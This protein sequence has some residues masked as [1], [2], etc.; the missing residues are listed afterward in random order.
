MLARRRL[1]GRSP[2][3]GPS[4]AAFEASNRFVFDAFRS[5]EDAAEYVFPHHLLCA[6]GERCAIVRDGQPLYWDRAHLSRFGAES[7]SVLFEPRF[8]RLTLLTH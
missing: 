5:G 6:D 7:L 1:Q 8:A 3:P 4:L 2:D